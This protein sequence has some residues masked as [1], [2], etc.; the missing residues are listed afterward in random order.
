MK[1]EHVFSFD[2][3]PGLLFNVLIRADQLNPFLPIAIG[4]VFH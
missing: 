2:F 3:K 1:I 4:T